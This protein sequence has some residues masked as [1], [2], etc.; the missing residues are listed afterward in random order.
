M[1]CKST[2]KYIKK[3]A[4]KENI[5]I[6]DDYENIL[7]KYCR[8]VEEM[9]YTLKFKKSLN[10]PSNKLNANAGFF[11]NS[12][13]IVTPE[14]AARLVMYS[15]EEVHNAFKITLGH[16]L[17]HKDNDLCF[18]KYRVKYYKFIAHVNEVHADFGGAQKMANAN[19]HI[20]L[21]AIDYKKSNK[22]V[23]KADSTHPSWEQRKY[24]AENY[25]F[26]EALIQQIAK[27]VGCKNRDIID[28]VCNHYQE[29][30]LN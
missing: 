24:Y 23:D 18:F 14:W 9:G 8:I 30:I 21:N 28:K 29:I 16:E 11:K 22:R 20:L 7:N 5:K 10:F 15:D 27:D 17:T 6:P 26:N 3:R 12:S 25:N 1:I 13:I 19:R 2:K 4:K